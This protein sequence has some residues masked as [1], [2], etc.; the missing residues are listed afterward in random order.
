MYCHYTL[1]QKQKII[2]RYLLL[3]MI[4]SN[5][6]WNTQIQLSIE[7]CIYAR[8]QRREFMPVLLLIK[9]SL[10]RLIWITIKFCYFSTCNSILK[11]LVITQRLIIKIIIDL[12]IMV[13]HNQNLVTIH[14]NKQTR[15]KINKFIILLLKFV[16]YFQ[17]I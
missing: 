1:L 6:W 4:D 7:Y 14:S 13:Y 16:T 15:K 3:L 11:N 12:K 17:N 10:F 2:N 5:L 9:T 8:K